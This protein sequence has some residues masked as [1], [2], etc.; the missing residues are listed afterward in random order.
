MADPA[1]PSLVVVLPTY[2]E[3]DNLDSITTRIRAAVP[4]AHI[5]VVD[6]NSPDGT[7]K[8]ADDLA[9][10]DPRIHVMHREGKAGL[11]SAYLAGF[12]W[13]LSRDYDVIVQ[14][15]AD[16]SHPAESLPGMV[17]KLADAEV[18]IG[19]RYV[20]GGSVVNWPVHRQALSRGGNLYSRLALGVRVKDITAGYRVFRREVL[21]ALALDQVASQGYCFQIDMVWRVVQAGFR[22]VEYPIVFTER[23]HGVSKMSGFIVREALWRV[24]TWGVNSRLGRGRGGSSSGR[25]SDGQAT[26]TVSA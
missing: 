14:M 6:D 9:S 26:D 18:V 24:T 21:A 22:I 10:E 19:S 15:D 4:A 1:T 5:L 25:S 20:S 12:A 7:G 11:G 3:R 2:N 8:I 16:G 13:A 23:E 17:A